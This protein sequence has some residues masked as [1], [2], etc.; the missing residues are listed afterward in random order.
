PCIFNLEDLH[1]LLEL[2]NHCPDW[3]LDKLTTLMRHNRY[4]AVHYSTIHRELKRAGISLKKLRKIA[5]E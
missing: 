4:I 5:K 2:I 1:Y 3:F